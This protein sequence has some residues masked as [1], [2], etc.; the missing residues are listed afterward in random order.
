M[1]YSHH[2][3][4]KHH[5]YKGSE[6]KILLIALPISIVIA[7]SIGAA[8]RGVPRLYWNFINN[9]RL[10]ET[11]SRAIIKGSAVRRETKLRER[12]EKQWRQDSLETWSKTYD[13]MLQNR[14]P[15]ETKELE[16]KLKDSQK[17]IY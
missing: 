1:S 6:K 17:G 7:F 12:Y 13:N 4:H 2:R 16:R 14:D 10:E 15:N 11:V 8:I 9:F 5:K 3:R